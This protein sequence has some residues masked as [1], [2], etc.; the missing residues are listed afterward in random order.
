MTEVVSACPRLTIV[1]AES[2]PIPGTS[3]A[4]GKQRQWPSV[5]TFHWCLHCADT[6]L[7]SHYSTCSF[8]TGCAVGVVT[9]T[10]Q[11]EEPQFQASSKLLQ[12]TQPTCVGAGA[13]PAQGPL[14]P[15]SVFFLATDAGSRHTLNVP[16]KRR[17]R[18]ILHRLILWS[19]I[20]SVLDSLEST[21]SVLTSGFE[22]KDQ[23]KNLE[24]FIWVSITLLPDFTSYQVIWRE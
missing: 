9:S 16:W 2:A 15:E 7:G 23:W 20:I 21:A 22:W 24:I 8:R 4:P 5:S 19:T 17:G 1:S 18:W 11:D 10:S 14:K 13:P 3:S 6:F 12:G